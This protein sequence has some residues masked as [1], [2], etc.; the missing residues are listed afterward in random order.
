MEQH[1]YDEIVRKCISEYGKFG[2]HKVWKE[3]CRQLN[4]DM[5]TACSLYKNFG[6]TYEEW[7]RKSGY[8]QDDIDG[9]KQDPLQKQGLFGDT[10]IICCPKCGS[11]AITY[12]EELEFH[13]GRAIIGALLGGL[14][15]SFIMG[16]TG[17]NKRY[18]VCMNC[19]KK[20]K[21]KR[22]R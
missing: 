6:I 8:H 14:E 4:V 16:A 19:G 20:W 15:G 9:K 21:I 7:K 12:V 5:R 13:S 22:K 2:H 18:A 10:A 3:I 11:A 17:K 1:S